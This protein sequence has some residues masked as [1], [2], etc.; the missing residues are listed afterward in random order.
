M[1]LAII[2]LAVSAI[3]SAQTTGREIPVPNSPAE[4]TLQ[5]AAKSIRDHRTAIVTLLDQSRHEADKENG[6]LIKQIENLQDQMRANVGRIQKRFNT[7][8]QQHQK[9]AMMDGSQI[10][11]LVQE[12]K[13]SSGLPEGAVF[14]VDTGKW[15]VPQK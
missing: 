7:L 10:P 3:G 5:A 9:Q 12:V 4:A 1:R 14:D 15:T 8:S 6:P 2:L 13:K 11:F